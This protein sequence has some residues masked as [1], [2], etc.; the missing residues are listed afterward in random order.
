MDGTVNDKSNAMMNK[1]KLSPAWS[2]KLAEQPET[3]MGFQDVEVTTK[4]GRKVDGI[5]L[6]GEFIETLMPLSETEIADIRVR[7]GKEVGRWG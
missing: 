3:G 1:V 5:A 4:G 2:K 7:T 6:N